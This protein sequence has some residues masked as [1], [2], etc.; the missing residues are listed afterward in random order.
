MVAGCSLHLCL[1]FHAG[2]ALVD[3]GASIT[4]LLD[5]QIKRLR[6]GAHL[7]LRIN[8]RR[9]NG[10]IRL[11]FCG[12][13]AEIEFYRL[14]KKEMALIWLTSTSIGTSAYWLMTIGMWSDHEVARLIDIAAL[15]CLVVLC[16]IFVAVG[17]SS[18]ITRSTPDTGAEPRYL[19]LHHPATTI[20]Q[21]VL[22]HGFLLILT[23]IMLIVV[24]NVLDSGIGAW[25]TAAV[26]IFPLIAVYGRLALHTKTLYE[27]H[28]LSER[29]IN[30]AHDRQ[31]LLARVNYDIDRANLLNQI[32]CD[33]IEKRAGRI[34]RWALNLSLPLLVLRL[35]TWVL[36]RISKLVLGPPNWIRGNAEHN[37][38]IDE[39][40]E[41][42]ILTG[43]LLGLNLV[44]VI[45]GVCH[46]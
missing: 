14:G 34:Y 45:G 38:T 19:S 32:R 15:L 31:S 40:M 35:A 1:A 2:S 21:D 20:G 29:H 28:I 6:V 23:V 16:D 17:T 22:L 42:R 10:Y 39:N 24:Y 11:E 43:F 37:C 4:G 12:S 5:R 25:V 9:A 30:I 7:D 8:R 44:R 36:E 26:A 27:S 33:Q 3:R 41:L 13:V 18:V 46:R